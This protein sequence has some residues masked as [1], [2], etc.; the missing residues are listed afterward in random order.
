MTDVTAVTLPTREDFRART[1][2]IPAEFTT[3]AGFLELGF[4]VMASL[5]DEIL[6]IRS[7]VNG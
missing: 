5:G 1:A 7:A 3:D 2:L 6:K 4:E